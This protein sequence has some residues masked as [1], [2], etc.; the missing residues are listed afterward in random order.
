M[1]D[2]ASFKK[3]GGPLLTQTLLLRK[4]NWFTEEY[5]CQQFS[6]QCNKKHHI[7]E[8]YKRRVE[9]EMHLETLLCLTNTSMDS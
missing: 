9:I 7:V 1:Q 6:E 5:K 2:E 3:Y 8:R 4:T